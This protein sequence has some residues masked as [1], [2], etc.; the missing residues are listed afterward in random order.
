[1]TARILKYFSINAL[2]CA[3]N[4]YIKPATIKN[5]ADLLTT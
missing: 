2:I 5:L 1:M 3:P 4:T